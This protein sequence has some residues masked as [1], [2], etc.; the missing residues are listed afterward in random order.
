MAKPKMSVPT[1]HQEQVALVQYAKIRAGQDNRWNMLVAY[2]NEGGRGRDN[3]IRGRLRQHEG[4]AK[5]F[6][7]LFL[8]VSCGKYH[9][10]A[11]EMKRVNRGAVSPEQRAWINALNEQG[12]YA[13]VCRGATQAIN[14]VESYLALGAKP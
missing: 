2:P 12:Y 14:L 13:V 10:L 3:I 8:F 4:S 5:G 9:G 1:E 11:I 6:P 7:D